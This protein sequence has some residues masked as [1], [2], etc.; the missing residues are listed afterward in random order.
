MAVYITPDDPVLLS[1]KNELA[2]SIATATLLKSDDT[3]LTQVTPL[4]CVKEDGSKEWFAFF[5]PFY[6]SPD[7]TYKI[8]W[9]GLATDGTDFTELETG[10]S[11]KVSNDFYATFM[12]SLRQAISDDGESCIYSPAAMLQSVKY[13]RDLINNYPPLTRL[14]IEYLPYNLLVDYSKIYLYRSVATSEMMNSF[15]YND[16]GKSFSFDRGPKLLQLVDN[17]T[18]G[19]DTQL[20]LYKK[21]LRPKF[22]GV[23]SRYARRSPGSARSL[24]LHRVLFR[25]FVR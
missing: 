7:L 13:A 23:M 17:L 24:M 18:R 11:V 21:H 15:T 9:D 19:A 16:I 10:L 14:S 3:E 25:N 8:R 6:F 12:L 22:A 2:A 1:F 4:D 5:D 20:A